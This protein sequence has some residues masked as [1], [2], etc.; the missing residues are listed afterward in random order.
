MLSSFFKKTKVEIFMT[1]KSTDF[2]A[3]LYNTVNIL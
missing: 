2:E 1:Y 3:A